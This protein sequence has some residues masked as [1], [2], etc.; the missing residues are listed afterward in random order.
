[1]T[2]TSAAAIDIRS[3]V[4]LHPVILS[5]HAFLFTRS[6]TGTERHLYG[7]RKVASFSTSA[8]T[9]PAFRSNQEDYDD[10]DED[11]IQKRDMEGSDTNDYTPKRHEIDPRWTERSKRWILLVDD[12]LSIRKAVVQLLSEKGYQVTACADARSAWNIAHSQR[13]DHATTMMDPS[14]WS[15]LPSSGPDAIVSDIRMPGMDGLE[16]LAKL[17]NDP[18]LIGTPVVLLTAKGLTQD[19]ITGYQYG[20]DAYLPK[21]F[22]GD[23]L[24]RYWTV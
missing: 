9:L 18:Q 11:T 17:R 24:V 6:R 14:E 8:F 23:E 19:R 3:V 12:E 10:E 5:A 1:M 21:P 13:I 4:S 7:S 20:A 22:D 15:S 16:F 2:I